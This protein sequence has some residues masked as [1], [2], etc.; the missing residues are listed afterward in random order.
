MR[1]ASAD[2]NAMKSMKA[3]SNKD[4]LNNTIRLFLYDHKHE[5]SPSA[6]ETIKIISRFAVKIPGVCWTKIE[7]LAE[8]IGKSPRT[9][10]RALKQLEDLGI[11]K[12]LKTIRKEG[13][14]GHPVI[15][16]QPIQGCV[17][18]DRVTSNVTSDLSDRQDVIKVDTPSVQESKNDTETK[19]PETKP[20]RVKEYD[21]RISHDNEIKLDY[22]YV[23]KEIPEE[24]V[25]EAKK[26]FGPLEIEDLWKRVKIAIKNTNYNPINK[27]E[28]AIDALKMTIKAYKK[29]TIHKTL[30]G[31]F[32]GTMKKMLKAN[33]DFWFIGDEEYI[34]SYLKPR[35]EGIV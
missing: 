3:F 23:N 6:I 33:R 10:L 22:S 13:G 35:N 31:F 27:T 28:I 1:I 12:R 16:I 9:I 20:L 21:I 30:G 2:Y 32:Y 14:Y 4:E 5:L 25:E 24:F 29:Q 8:K 7:T 17:L 18:P 15:V 11:I 34:P 19:I 26:G